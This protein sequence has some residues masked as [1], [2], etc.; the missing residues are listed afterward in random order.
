MDGTLNYQVRRE[1]EMR[2]AR[3]LPTSESTLDSVA[4]SSSESTI[5]GGGGP[6]YPKS[7]GGAPASG[8]EQ[9]RRRELGLQ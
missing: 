7:N 6:T 9:Q 8:Y 3:G 1:T 2:L 5:V 4:D